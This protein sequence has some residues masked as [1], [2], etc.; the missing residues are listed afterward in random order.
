MPTSE[1]MNPH[2]QP[3]D[4]PQNPRKI[5]MVQIQIQYKEENNYKDQTRN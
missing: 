4:A 5:K 1:K 3:N 2:K